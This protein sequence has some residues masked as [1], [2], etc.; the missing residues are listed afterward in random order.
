MG[1][2]RKELRLILVGVWQGIISE[3]EALQRI[4][5]LKQE[6]AK[7]ASEVISHVRRHICTVTEAEEDLTISCQC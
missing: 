6:V 2:K 4:S 1:Q 3:K 7:N 5:V